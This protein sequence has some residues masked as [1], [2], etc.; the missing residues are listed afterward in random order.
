M[1]NPEALA[2]WKAENQEFMQRPAASLP[3]LQAPSL[4]DAFGT[5]NTWDGYLGNY[6]DAF[7]LEYPYS[8]VGR[9]YFNDGYNIYNCTA[10]LINYDVIVTAAHCVYDTD[11]NYWYGGWQFVPA[12]WNYASIMPWGYYNYYSATILSKWASAKKSSKGLSSDVAILELYGN[13]T[14]PYAGYYAG[15]LGYSWNTSTKMVHHAIG[16]PSNIFSGISSYICVGESFSNKGG[17]GLG[18][19]MTYGSSGGPWIL[20]FTP[21]QFSYPWTAYGNYVNSVV[22]GGN[23]SY[24]T[25]YGPRFT[26]SNIG[27]LCWGTGLC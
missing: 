7:W 3:A 24:P 9:L 25:F 27:M 15:W 2:Q 13:G 22:S 8:T 19:D 14:A 6:F 17:L 21:Y 26:T 20:W 12:D 5:K 11:Y 10:S 18:C 23:P 16:Y 4:T 1:P